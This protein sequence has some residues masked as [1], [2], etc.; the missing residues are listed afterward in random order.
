MHECPIC[1]GHGVILCLKDRIFLNG[2]YWEFMKQCW[3]SLC[4]GSGIVKVEEKE[5]V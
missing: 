4:L 3:C 1:S 5:R 2:K